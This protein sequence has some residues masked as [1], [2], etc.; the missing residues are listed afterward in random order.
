MEQKKDYCLE[1]PCGIFV[2]RSHKDKILTEPLNHSE[3]E[4]MI[5]AGAA[6]TDERVA[7]WNDAEG[8]NRSERN[9]RYCEMTAVYWVWKHVQADYIGI[10]H[11]R[12]KFILCDQELDLCMKN[13]V[14]AILPQKIPLSHDIQTQFKKNH[15]HY[16]W[17]IMMELLKQRA[18]PY[19]ETALNVFQENQ[20]TCFNMGI[21]REKV[22]DQY[23][24]WL[25]P[26]LDEF[27]QIRPEKYD[28]HQRRDI[29]FLSER[30]SHLFWE[31][32]KNE[33]KIH[34]ATV[35]FPRPSTDLVESYMEEEECYRKVRELIAGHQIQKSNQIVKNASCDGKIMKEL[36]FLFSIYHM[37]KIY[38]D[39]TIFDVNFDGNLDYLLY[40]LRDMLTTLVTYYHTADELAGR[41]LVRLLQ[42]YR[43]SYVVVMQAISCFHLSDVLFLDRLIKLFEQNGLQDF[44]RFFEIL[45]EQTIRSKGERY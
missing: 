39:N 37:E 43:F 36:E 35:K 28:L 14:D 3:Y 41:Q 12:R 21:Y 13:H 25:F 38:M 10:S 20:M 16:D 34:R 4:I 44:A 11:Y 32:H 7:E 40:K 45:Y 31:H 5:Q 9:Q 17:N 33:F 8:D 6:L 24:S 27:Y 26:L 23:C 42:I 29:G 15:Y 30:L 2:I 22:F 18:N 1:K 19:Y